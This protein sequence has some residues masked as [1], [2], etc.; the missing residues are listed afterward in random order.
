MAGSQ[1]SRKVADRIHE[2]VAE[3]CERKI[4]D[5]RL[6][7][8]TITEVRVNSDL[9][10]AAIFYTVFGDTEARAG[11]AAAFES[12]KGLIRSAVGKEL[13]ARVTPTLEFIADAI[14]ETAAHMEKLLAETAAHDAEIAAASSNS[15]F[16]GDANP[17]K[18]HR[19]RINKFDE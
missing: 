17:Y 15:T 6:G 16:A 8:V 14:P 12:A 11:T 9:Q 7:F 3:M 10:H 5:P 13:G 2:V 1:R 18:E 4:K 19:E